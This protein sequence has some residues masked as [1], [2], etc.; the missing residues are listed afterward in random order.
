M[1]ATPSDRSKRIADAAAGYADNRW[2]NWM[3]PFAVA[4]ALALWTGASLDLAVLWSGLA[5]RLNLLSDRAIAAQGLALALVVVAGYAVILAV[6]L[7]RGERHW[8]GDPQ[9]TVAEAQLP[10]RYRWFR[11]G[12]EAVG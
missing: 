5:I 3:T 1:T 12:Y 2:L 6:V 4:G 9:V 8:R 11:W 10:S 7:S